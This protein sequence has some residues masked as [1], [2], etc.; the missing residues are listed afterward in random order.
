LLD[1][2]AR[3]KAPSCGDSFDVKKLRQLVRLRDKFSSPDNVD[4]LRDKIIL[5]SVLSQTGEMKESLEIYAACLKTAREK[6]KGLLPELLLSYSKA[7]TL[8]KETD[9]ALPLLQEAYRLSGPGPTFNPIITPEIAGDL[10]FLLEQ[11]EKKSEAAKVYES[12]I[13]ELKARNNTGKLAYF[14]NSLKNCR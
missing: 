9:K 10:G 13:K 4:T 2:Y 3:S 12:I 6:C 1:Q 7:L 14:E 5:A 11:K 8:N